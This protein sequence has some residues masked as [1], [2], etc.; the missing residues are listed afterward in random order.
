MGHRGIASNLNGRSTW[1]RRIYYCVEINV[2]LVNQ[3]FRLAPISG[4]LNVGLES[5]HKMV[6]TKTAVIGMQS[7]ERQGTVDIQVFNFPE[8]VLVYV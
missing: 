5:I 8:D 4:P 2:L 7:I 6:A 3:S 1:I